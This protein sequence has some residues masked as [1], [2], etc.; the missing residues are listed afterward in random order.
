MQLLTTQAL[1]ALLQGAT[2]ALARLPI[3]SP[4]SLVVPLS[5]PS[6]TLSWLPLSYS[7]DCL[8]PIPSPQSHTLLALLA[9]SSTSQGRRGPRPKAA[10]E[11]GTGGGTHHG[12]P[13]QGPPS[14]WPPPWRTS[15]E[16][17][18]QTPWCN[19]GS[20]ASRGGGRACAQTA[21]ATDTP[22][23]TEWVG[24]ERER[25]RR[26]RRRG[27]SVEARETRSVE[28]RESSFFRFYSC[29]WSCT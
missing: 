16:R 6:L 11:G 10:T 12:V 21:A 26:E 29:T 7:L 24:G 28:A 15:P 22:T 27:E 18:A 19:G 5:L 17:A 20:L 23:T 4:A 9:S 3:T 14:G 8:P 13:W 25:R 2:H 1:H